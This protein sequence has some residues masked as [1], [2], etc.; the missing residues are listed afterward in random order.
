MNG[1]AIREYATVVLLNLTALGLIVWQLRDPQSS[2][3]LVEPA[4]TVTPAPSPTAVALHVHVSGAVLAPDVVTLA[5][6]ARAR[7]AIAA[8]GGFARD[9]ERSAVNLAAAL[10]DGQQLHV[11]TVGEAP[12]PPAG[13]SGPGASAGGTS[14]DGA[15]AASGASAGG[16]VNVNAATEAELQSLP[17]VGPALAG[18]IVAHREENGPFASPEDLL[19]VSGIGEKTLAGF[20]D[21]VAVR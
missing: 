8:A 17:G 12:L 13:V 21:Q 16:K 10:A 20:L 6:G 7:D 18:R 11:P 2:A 19:A 1:A 3:V 4:P 14:G 5:E 9:A 15:S